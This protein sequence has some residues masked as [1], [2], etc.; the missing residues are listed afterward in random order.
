MMII[1]LN[2]IA[3]TLS[4]STAKE[5]L[6]Y[7]K[8]LE[9]RTTTGSLVLQLDEN[10]SLSLVKS[11]VVS[12]SFLV[13]TSEEN[14]NTYE[15]VDASRINE[16]LYHDPQQRSSL[17]ILRGKNALEVE[18]VIDNKLRIKPLLEKER[19]SEGHVLH[20]IYEVE[21]IKDDLKKI[22]PR[23]LRTSPLRPSARNYGSGYWWLQ[24]WGRGTTTRRPKVDEFVV[25]VHIVSCKEHQAQFSTNQELI[26]YLAVM[27][28]AVN[29]RY[30]DMNSPRIKYKLVGVTRS[31]N[32]VFAV[33]SSGILDAEN[34]LR[35]LAMYYSQGYIP[36]NPDVVYFITNQD[37]AKINY[38]VVT[39]KNIAGL[40]F[41]GTVCTKRGVAEGEDIA[42]SYM[43]VYCMAH[44]LAHS[45]GADHDLTPEC[46]WSHG[47]LMSYV[48]GGTNKYRLSRCS[49]RQIRNLIP[50]LP[51]SCVKESSNQN[52]MSN[53]RSVP[54]QVLKEF[55]YCKMMLKKQ[56]RSNYISA[57]KPPQLI[58]NCKMNCCYRVGYTKW[59]Q[60]NDMLEGMSCNYGQSC[61]RGVC[62]NH[63]WQN[64]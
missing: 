50:T 62:G 31:K 27:L 14:R 13:V 24:P 59:C 28:N 64:K 21:E 38:G 15:T 46:P 41:L 7:P 36:G 58:N 53:H 9:E 63:H 25:E 45:L 3:I 17:R 61:R 34:T 37:L 6:V 54:G 20:S 48:D 16:A 2:V 35:G 22:S 33:G 55:D 12:D 30:L 10:L 32:D 19:S 8:I 47:Y 52:Y 4:C 5:I 49:Q 51:P 40:A 26:A 1:S 60:K 44:E 43:G 56:G 23:H 29:M 39:Q 18:G 11:S 57:E 42:K